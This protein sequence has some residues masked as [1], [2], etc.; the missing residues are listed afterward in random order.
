LFVNGICKCL[1]CCLGH[2][3]HTIE[4]KL[5]NLRHVCGLVSHILKI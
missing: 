4:T 3:A 2:I 1:P 5:F